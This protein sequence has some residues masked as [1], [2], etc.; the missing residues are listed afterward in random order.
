VIDIT[1]P[2][3]LGGTGGGLLLAD[4]NNPTV[5]AN[6]VPINNTDGIVNFGNFVRSGGLSGWRGLH[7][8]TD[9]VSLGGMGSMFFRAHFGGLR[10][11]HRAVTANTTQIATD[12]T[13]E[14]TDGS[15]TITLLDSKPL[16]SSLSSFTNL[17]GG[18]KGG[19]LCIVNNGVG[20][21]TAQPIGII[22]TAGVTTNGST[23]ISYGSN[24]QTPNVGDYVSGTNIPSETRVVSAT[25]TTAV[26]SAAATDSGTG[27]TFTFSESV[28]GMSSLLF[29]PGNRRILQS[30][31]SGWI[32]LTSP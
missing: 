12:F 15:P 30:T 1:N 23:S 27:I 19:L 9:G 22:R 6:V 25:A 24:A 28:D 11:E 26:L 16:N 21:V 29:A 4:R 13:I 2:I 17:E 32:T 7:P 8:A 31:G 3:L 18:A 5:G 14:V 10:T 20:M